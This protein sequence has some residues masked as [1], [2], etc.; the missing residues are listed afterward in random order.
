MN[1]AKTSL[2]V[3]FTA[4]CIES[5]CSKE[6]F[7]ILLILRRRNTV[8]VGAMEG[9]VMY[10]AFDKTIG[11]VDRRRLVKLVRNPRDR[12]EIYDGPPAHSFDQGA[13]DHDRPKIIRAAEIY[14]VFFGRKAQNVE[15]GIDNA[16]GLIG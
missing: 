15:N 6:L 5:N 8:I 16:R 7:K 3:R 12:R 13:D 2:L 14:G 10:T 4:F 9:S 1:V 11:A